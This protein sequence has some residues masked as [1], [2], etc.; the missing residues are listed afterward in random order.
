MA[1]FGGD[2]TLFSL[3]EDGDFDVDGVRVLVRCGEIARVGKLRYLLHVVGM[4]VDFESCCHLVV[5]CINEK[6]FKYFYPIR[7]E[8]GIYDTN[9]RTND[10]RR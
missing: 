8:F 7:N 4:T 5:S 1:S 10:I 3:N 2:R 9:V 6:R